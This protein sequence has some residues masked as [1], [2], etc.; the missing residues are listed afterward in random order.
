M[1]N[2]SDVVQETRCHFKYK[3]FKKHALRANKMSM[4]QDTL[5]TNNYMENPNKSECLAE[6]EPTPSCTKGGHANQ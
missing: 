4:T 5:S 3:D 2:E 6:F 1:N